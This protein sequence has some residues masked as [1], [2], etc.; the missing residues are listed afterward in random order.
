MKKILLAEDDADLAGVLK[1]YLELQGYSVVHCNNGHAAL[2]RLKQENFDIC[3][4][5]IMMPMV[6][7]FTVAENLNRNTPFVFL[8]ARK[9]KD[10]RLKG[11]KLGADDYIIKPFE[12]DELV[13]RI[14]NILKR[15]AQAENLIGIEEIRIGNYIFDSQRLELKHEYLIQQLTVK[16]GALLQFLFENRNTLVNREDILKAVW[17]NSDFFS[18]RSM[19]VYISKLRK[20]LKNDSKLTIV[21]IRHLG[22]EFKVEK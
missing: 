19:D 13:L 10:D 8:T 11:L 22:I 20:Y 21:V 2:Q 7:G 14:N 6:D 16:E 18:G 4:L 17:Q 3:V 15:S 5:D 9:L 1:Q 12:A